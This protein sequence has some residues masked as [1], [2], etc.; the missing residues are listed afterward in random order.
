MAQETTAKP[1]RLEQWD[2]FDKQV[3]KHIPEYT[4]VQYGNKEG[5][6]QADN[7]T[8][9]ECWKHIDR[10]RNRSSSSVRGPK[11]KLRDAI[12]VAHYAQFIYD[13][14]R[15]ALDEPDVY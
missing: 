9:E 12:K 11:E 3:R 8:I 1:T 6:E 7:F 2:H 5:D 4:E 13:K 14:L 10:Y 15:I